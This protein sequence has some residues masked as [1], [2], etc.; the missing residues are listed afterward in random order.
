MA[1]ES[2]TG[3]E[4]NNAPSR[5]MRSRGLI[6]LGA[7]L[8]CAVGIGLIGDGIS[9]I[10]TKEHGEVR[11]G[12][13]VEVGAGIST[14]LGGYGMVHAL[15][16]KSWRRREEAEE[17]ELAYFE[18]VLEDAERRR[19]AARTPSFTGIIVDGEVVTW[20]DHPIPTDESPAQLPPAQQDGTWPQFRAGSS[21]EL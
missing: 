20:S 14:I 8:G 6:S 19:D 1:A 17:V 10:D 16:R 7:L 11:T 21:E 9:K 12:E 13:I 4:E 18:A 5:I 3:Y 2:K 15:Y